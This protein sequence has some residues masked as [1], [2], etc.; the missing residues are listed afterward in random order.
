MT[1]EVDILSK[2]CLNVFGHSHLWSRCKRRLF[3]VLYFTF[4]CRFSYITVNVVIFAG[5]KRSRKCWQDISHGRN[6]HDTTPTS[7]IKAFGFYFRAGVIFAKKT[8]ARKT[9]KLPPRK[10]FHVYNIQKYMFICMYVYNACFNTLC[11]KS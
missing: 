7:F 6:F 5:G 9:R 8:K 3:C 11:V 1:C 10:E 4:G 2:H